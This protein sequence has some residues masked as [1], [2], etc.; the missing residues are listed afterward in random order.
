MDNYKI[1][2]V[3]PTIWS[4]DLIFESISKLDK[5]DA[6]G[7]IIIINN[8]PS[9]N[10]CTYKS[11]KIIEYQFSENIFVNPAW[12]FGVKH[13]K[14]NKICLLNDDVIVD[15][16]AFYYA[17]F[18][19]DNNEIGIIGASKTCFKQS[20]IYNIE[21]ILVRNRGFGTMLFLTK[22]NY[23]PIPDDLKIWFGDDW[24][25]K[26][27]EGRVFRMKG[28]FIRT[29]MSSSSENPEFKSIIDNDVKN[30]LKYELPWSND[31]ED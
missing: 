24:L 22:Q 7:E 23:N 20:D 30:S 10:V 1:S 15:E 26:Y 29:V 12:N 27:Y 5:C 11:N 3:I 18:L 16:L 14:F 25:I 31:F 6:I 4:S 21:K 19:L 2:V 28:P 8:K 17:L 9:K 13:A